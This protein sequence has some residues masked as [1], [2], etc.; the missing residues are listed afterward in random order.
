MLLHGRYGVPLL[1]QLPSNCPPY[2]RQL[3]NLQLSRDM[4]ARAVTVSESIEGC[5]SSHLESS[6]W[7][8]AAT[9]SERITSLHRRESMEVEFADESVCLRLQRWHSEYP[10]WATIIFGVP[11]GV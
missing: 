9:L 10:Q 7:Y 8:R 4:N 3:W 6:D 1:L 2:L 5:K 11:C